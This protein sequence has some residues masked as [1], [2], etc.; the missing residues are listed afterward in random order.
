[1][2]SEES[3]NLAFPTCHPAAPG[4]IMSIAVAMIALA[5]VAVLAGLVG[6]LLGLGGAVLIIPFL[7][8]VLH[9]NIHYAI[10]ASIVA[11]ICTSSSAGAVYARSGIANIRL[12]FLLECGAVVGA[13]TGALLATILAAR[14]L[15]FLFAAILVYSAASMILSHRRENQRI[16]IPTAGDASPFAGHFYDAQEKRTVSYVPHRPYLGVPLVF[17]SGILSALLG[18]GAGGINVPAFRSILH[19]PLK[20]ALGTSSYMIGIIAATSA[21]IYTFRGDVEP[22]LAAPIACGILVGARIGAKLLPRLQHQWLNRAFIVLL[23]LLAGEM[24]FHGLAA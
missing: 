2:N 4:E 9:V 13:V 3:S 11:V 23:L 15:F 8:L 17:A 21:L 10:G 18:V 6:S 20:A 19:L 16:G 14:F 1:M 24:T 7:T 12:A 5:V 22:L